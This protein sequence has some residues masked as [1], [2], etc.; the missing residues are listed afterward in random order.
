M[1]LQI[2]LKI[3]PTYAS[4]QL[5]STISYNLIKF[6]LDFGSEWQSYFNSLIKAS[7]QSLSVNYDTTFFFENRKNFK[8]ILFNKINSV[9]KIK[10]NKIVNL[11]SLQLQQIKLN[12]IIEK[13]INDKLVQFQ[14]IKLYSINDQIFTINKNTE[15]LIKQNSADIDFLTSNAKSYYESSKIYIHSNCTDTIMK[16]D[17]NIYSELD[18]SLYLSFEGNLLNFISVLEGKDYTPNKFINFNSISLSEQGQ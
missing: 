5:N 4:A 8:N 17:M 9:V 2:F 3:D 12:P 7:I 16:S 14:K 11:Y 1:E 6:Y 15:R 10:S 18:N 13:S